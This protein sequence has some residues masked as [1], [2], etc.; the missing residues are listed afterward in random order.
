[1]TE[2]ED[3]SQ[4]LVVEEKLLDLCLQLFDDQDELMKYKRSKLADSFNSTKYQLAKSLADAHKQLHGLKRE[5]WD[6]IS[7]YFSFA[8][9]YLF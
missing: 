8:G 9:D 5:L 1:M 3:V 2:M 7:M 4:H 6:E